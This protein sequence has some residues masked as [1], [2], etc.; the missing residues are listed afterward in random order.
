M[1]VQCPSCHTTYRASDIPITIPN[2]TFRCSRCKHIFVLGLKPETSPVREATSPPSTTA[3]PD[4]EEDRELSFSFSPPKRKEAREEKSKEDFDFLESKEPPETESPDQGQPESPKLEI[5]ESFPPPKDTPALRIAEEQPSPTTEEEQPLPT[6]HEGPQSSLNDNS[7]T[8][9]EEDRSPRIDTTPEA[10]PELEE[11]WQSPSPSLEEKDATL[12]LDPYRGLSA[13]TMP[14]LSLFGVLLLIY[15]LL[16][17]MHQTQPKSVESFIKAIPL[18]GSSVFK[19]NHLRQRIALQSLR[20]SFQTIVGNRQVFVI[21]GVA[22]N[23]NPVSVREVQV[24]GHIYNAAGKEIKRQDIWVGNAI[25]PKI[26]RDLTAQEISIL[27]KL[28]PQKR[29]Q[30]PPEESAG[31]VIIFL[32]PNGEIKDFSCRVL[33]ADGEV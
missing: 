25:S 17:L 14:Y 1:L 32:K 33:S 24:E 16:T 23:R 4:E 11:D 28:S 19:N 27:Q 3:Q 12:A 9:P 6:I 18:L 10:D 8:I 26:I 31:F 20:P 29:F 2:P 21:S 15:S 5:D 7:I 13:S 22:V 30:I